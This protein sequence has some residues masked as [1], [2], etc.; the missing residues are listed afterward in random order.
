M[1]SLPEKQQT[2]DSFFTKEDWESNLQNS[3]SNFLLLAAPIVKQWLKCESIISNEKKTEQFCQVL[4]TKSGIDFYATYP[5]GN[6]F[7]ATRIQWD[8]SDKFKQFYKESFPYDNFTIRSQSQGGGV[9]E[10]YKRQQAKEK[11]LL[12]PNKVIQGF[13]SKKQNG[14][15]LS[16]AMCNQDD[17]ID[18]VNN[19][20][21]EV[22]QR[23]RENDFL[24]IYWDIFAKK[25]YPINLFYSID[26]SIWKNIKPNQYRPKIK[27]N[28]GFEYFN[29]K[30]SLSK[31]FR[32]INSSEQKQCDIDLL[33]K[34]FENEIM[35]FE[36]L[37]RLENL[38]LV[39]S[40]PT[41]NSIQI[42]KNNNGE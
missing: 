29:Y 21:E 38:G 7:L 6:S 25:N 31:I 41:T 39:V 27:D 40:N 8:G 42:K 19:Y 30:L 17:L 16:L 12:R 32:Y 23:R 11:N 20:P 13:I 2:L 5:D 3:N 36:K 24:I 4:D 18:F 33:S 26:Y 22:E 14:H 15:L 1:E 28:F 35:F 37:Q 9:T 10:L 34:V